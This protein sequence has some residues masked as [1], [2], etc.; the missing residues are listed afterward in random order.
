MPTESGAK[1]DATSGSIEF[2]DRL[3]EAPRAVVPVSEPKHDEAVALMKELQAVMRKH[4]IK[5]D[6]MNPQ[7]MARCANSLAN[8]WSNNYYRMTEEKYSDKRTRP[9]H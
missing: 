8:M 1:N 3:T 2:P 9:N 7:D 4:Y 6:K 5:S